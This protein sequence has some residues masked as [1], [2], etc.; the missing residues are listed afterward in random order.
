MAVTS[1]CGEVQRK[2]MAIPETVID[3]GPRLLWLRK[4]WMDELGL[5][6]PKTLDDA[7]EIIEAFV[8]NG[9]G[10]EEGEDPVGLVCDTNLVGSTSSSYSVEPVFDRY[11][12]RGHNS[13]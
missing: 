8:E 13:G 12:M 10:A 9:M 7:F 1:G 4:D 6:E 2:L 3:H 5:D 11:A